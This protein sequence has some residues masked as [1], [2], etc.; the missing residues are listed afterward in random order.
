VYEADLEKMS[1][2]LGAIEEYKKRKAD[3]EA[4]AAE[5]D[6]VT[7]Q[8]DEVGGWVGVMQSTER[9]QPGE[10]EGREVQVSHRAGDLHVAASRFVLGM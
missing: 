1:V 9:M 10:R 4:R 8:R 5:L 2:D 3:Y 6:A 7:A